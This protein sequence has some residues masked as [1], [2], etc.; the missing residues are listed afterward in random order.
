MQPIANYQYPQ[1]YQTAYNQ[2]SQPM[3]P[4][5]QVYGQQPQMYGQQ[6]MY[7]QQPNGYG[8]NGYPQQNWGQRPY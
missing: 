1:S 2:Y 4:Q 7:Y 5:Q 3:Y 6:P 8:Q